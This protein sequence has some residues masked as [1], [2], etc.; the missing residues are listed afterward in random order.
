[1]AY[2]PTPLGKDP[3]YDPF[4][5]VP[6]GQDRRGISVNVVSM[7]ARMGVDP[8][9]EASYL[10]KLSD[11][12]AQQRLEA[13]MARFYDVTA[14][15]GMGRSKVILGLLA[16]LPTQAEPTSPPPPDS[17]ATGKVWPL[18]GSL[19]VWLVAAV[20]LLGCARVDGAESRCRHGLCARQQKS[21]RHRPVDRR[22]RDPGGPGGNACPARQGESPPEA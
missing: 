8:W 1:M 20:L 3:R 5:A 18:P 16:F 4:L 13:L 15:Q 19:I 17:T 2:A 11:G 14:Q 12:A 10:A 7:L 21:C 6:V 9:G 22:P